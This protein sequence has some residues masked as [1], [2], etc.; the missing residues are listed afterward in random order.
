MEVAEPRPPDT[1]TVKE[2][3]QHKTLL[4]KQI[5]EALTTFNEQYPEAVV[6]SIELETL[7]SAANYPIICA[8]K[9]ATLIT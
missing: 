9:V 6:D 7:N 2:F 8:V 3:I 5:L 1:R 4:E